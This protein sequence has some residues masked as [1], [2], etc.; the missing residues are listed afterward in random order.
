MLWLNTINIINSNDECLPS[1]YKS[2]PVHFQIKE[3]Q[4][5]KENN[6]NNSY[7]IYNPDLVEHKDIQIKNNNV[8][9][10]DNNQINIV[11][12]NQILNESPEYFSLFD[13][14]KN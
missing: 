6:R 8:N 12:N 11:N 3:E 1:F 9:N 13:N 14:D 2:A 10:F 7:P 4:I 5:V